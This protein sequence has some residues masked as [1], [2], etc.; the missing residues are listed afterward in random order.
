LVELIGAGT[1]LPLNRAK[2]LIDNFQK[3]QIELTKAANVSKPENDKQEEVQGTCEDFRLRMNF[4]SAPNFILTQD[5]SPTVVKD[6]WCVVRNVLVSGGLSRWTKEWKWI[7]Y[8]KT[9]CVARV[10]RL[11]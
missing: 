1:V 7:I 10:K 5:H 2:S 9:N 6:S 8:L 4:P 3:R 11:Y